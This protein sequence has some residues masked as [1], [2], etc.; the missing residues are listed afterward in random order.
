MEQRRVE[1]RRR[2]KA[3]LPPPAK[4]PLDYS[5]PERSWLLASPRLDD[6]QFL[7][8]GFRHDAVHP[9]AQLGSTPPAS[10]PARRHGPWSRAWW[11]VPPGSA[12]AGCR[13]PHGSRSGCCSGAPGCRPARRPSAGHPAVQGVPVIAANCAANPSSDSAEGGE[14]ADVQ[15]VGHGMHVLED[16]DQVALALPGQ[17]IDLRRSGR[18]RCRPPR[19]P[20]CSRAGGRRRGSRSRSRCPCP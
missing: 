4:D 2:W 8:L 7:Q 3:R 11:R 9:A 6:L 12:W 15:A 17:R 10:C 13:C 19:P 20:G 1:K 16:H 14:L 18:A 5:S